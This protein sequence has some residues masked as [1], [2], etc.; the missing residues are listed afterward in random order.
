MREIYRAGNLF[1]LVNLAR[2]R[3]RGWNLGFQIYGEFS[4]IFDASG[5]VESRY[6]RCL[7]KYTH[8]DHV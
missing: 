1:T 8:F 7:W 5:E 6:P 4:R 3:G 2:M